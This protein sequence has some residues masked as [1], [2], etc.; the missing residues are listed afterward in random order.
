MEL[1]SVI[2]VLSKDVGQMVRQIS[3]S[4]NSIME[5]MLRLSQGSIPADYVAGGFIRG[6]AL[7]SAAG[8]SLRV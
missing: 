2:L 4:T 8:I 7:L 3:V 6:D 5:G 1:V